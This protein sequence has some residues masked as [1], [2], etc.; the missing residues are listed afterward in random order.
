M[1]RSPVLASQRD[2]YTQRSNQNCLEP[3]DQA[4]S[5]L[6]MGQQQSSLLADRE[7]THPPQGPPN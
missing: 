6:S 1:K 5:G 3:W 7:I 4:G 2:G